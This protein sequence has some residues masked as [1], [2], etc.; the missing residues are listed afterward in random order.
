MQLTKS[1]SLICVF[2]FMRRPFNLV[3]IYYWWASRLN[4]LCCIEEL[5]DE[6]MC[7]TRK[8]TN[9]LGYQ[10]VNFKGSKLLSILMAE[11]HT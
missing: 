8:C 2:F 3:L 11:G 5:M 9:L 4:S 6:F 7:R 10:R 1:L